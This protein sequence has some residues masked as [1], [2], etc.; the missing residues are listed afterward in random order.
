MLYRLHLL[1][2]LLLPLRPWCLG[3]AG[4]AASLAGYALLKS[5]NS[6]TL[7]LRLSLVLA[8]WL[9]LSYACIGLFQQ[10]PPPVLPLDRWWQRAYTR[11]RLLCYQCL[12]LLM[13]F[14]SLVLLSLSL[15]L[16]FI[17]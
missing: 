16:L 2:R 8:L 17:R 9:L 1:A 11:L 10:L 14:T 6:P 12:A 3:L 13:G 7:L 15:K 4:L 5:G